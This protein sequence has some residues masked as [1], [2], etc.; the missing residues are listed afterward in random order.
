MRNILSGP[1]QIHTAIQRSD[2]LLVTL[3]KAAIKVKIIRPNKFMDHQNAVISL[4]LG[5]FR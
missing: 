3:Q 5:A 1:H 4:T 2:L